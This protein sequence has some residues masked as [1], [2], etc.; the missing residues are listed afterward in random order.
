VI[1]ALRAGPGRTELRMR[2]DG[3]ELVAHLPPDA[4]ALRPGDRVAVT[5]L[6]A[7]CAFTDD[8]PE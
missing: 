6:P 3:V 5:A 4:A 8:G 2:V 7:A 1:S